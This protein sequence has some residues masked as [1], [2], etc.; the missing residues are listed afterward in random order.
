MPQQPDGAYLPLNA[1][2]QAYTSCQYRHGIP[3]PYVGKKLR[4]AIEDLHRHAQSCQS[5]RNE[6]GMTMHYLLAAYLGLHNMLAKA[7]DPTLVDRL[8]DGS[9]ETLQK[10]LNLVEREGDVYGVAA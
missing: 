9:R 2:G 1:N 7:N 8:L 3:L 10:W 4:C 5:K 6:L